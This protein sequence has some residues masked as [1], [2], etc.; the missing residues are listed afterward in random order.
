LKSRH[1]FIVTAVL[2]AATGVALV[3]APSVP[4]SLLLGASLDTPAGLAIG[5]VAGS[6]LLSLGAACWLARH[7]GQSRAARGLIAAMFFYNIAAVSVLA[8]AGLGPRL[9]GVGLWPAVVLHV[10]M[11]AWCIACLR[12]DR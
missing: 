1:L 3:L 6:A 7:D 4:L 10:A 8:Y 12:T 9:S 2:E 5:R 11:A